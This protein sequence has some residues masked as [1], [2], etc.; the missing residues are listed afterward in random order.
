RADALRTPVIS[1]AR[2]NGAIILPP[3]VNKPMGAKSALK[4]PP[5]TPAAHFSRGMV[6]DKVSPFGLSITRRVQDLAEKIARS[7]TAL[8]FALAFSKT[9]CRCAMPSRPGSESLERIVQSACAVAAT[10]RRSSAAL[11]FATVF[12]QQ[13]LKIRI[14]S[15]RVPNRIYFQT[16]HCDSTRPPQQSVQNCNRAIVVAENSVNFGHSNRNFRAAKRV[17]AFG[18]QFG[19]ALCLGQ[20]E[21][22]FAEV[23]EHFRQLNVDL[24]GV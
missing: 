6:S 24:R 3:L 16:R 22:F 5:F 12:G 20:R 10:A 17:L 23:R 11:R 14:V 13:S 7:T 1:R 18:K 19:C 8:S 9:T 15:Q 2:C 21:V 4:Y